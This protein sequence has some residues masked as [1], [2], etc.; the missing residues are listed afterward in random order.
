MTSS[1]SRA[2]MQIRAGLTHRLASMANDPQ[3][4]SGGFMACPESPH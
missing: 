4:G 3:Y 2:K 1:F